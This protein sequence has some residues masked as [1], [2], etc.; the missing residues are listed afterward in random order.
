VKMHR[1]IGRACAAAVAVFAMLFALGGCG[2]AGVEGTGSGR[3]EE[4]GG[5]KGGGDRD[6]G[7]GFDQAALCTAPFAPGSLDCAPAAADPYDGTAP[8]WWSDGD[9]QS[10]R[11]ATVVATLEGN[12]ISLRVQCGT[13]ATFTGLWGQLQDGSLAFVG[14]YVVPDGSEGV[15]AIAQ[16]LAAPD[17][18]GSVGRLQVTAPSG[19]I[20]FGP[21]PMR[22]APGASAPPPCAP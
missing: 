7:I 6:T 13:A 18:P 10:A 5:D 9:A 1:R 12:G 2:G 8:V 16:V 21:W 3:E 22:R 20:L 17:E 14:S 15:P 4:G 11:E 19:T